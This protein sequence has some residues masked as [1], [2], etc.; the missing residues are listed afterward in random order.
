M[1]KLIF[2]LIASTFVATAAAQ[3]G[4]VNPATVADHGTPAM[5][6]AETQ[7][8]VAASKAVKGLSETKAQQQALKDATKLADQGTPVTRAENAEQN[9]NASKGTA[10]QITSAKVGQ[11]AVKAAVKGQTK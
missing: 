11:E 1:N 10:T 3:T 9:T 2:A 4:T 8:N 6:A 7:K 5:H